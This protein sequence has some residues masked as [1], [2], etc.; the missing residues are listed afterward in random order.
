MQQLSPPDHCDFPVFIRYEVLSG[1]SQR[2]WDSNTVQSYKRDF[3]LTSV[4]QGQ[5]R[6]ERPW[7]LPFLS[8]S[9]LV[10]PNLSRIQGLPTSQEP[11]RHLLKQILIQNL[12]PRHCSRHEWRAAGQY[13][14]QG[15]RVYW[16]LESE[17]G[18]GQSFQE[19]SVFIRTRSSR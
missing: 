13:H 4:S 8:V 7:I 17:Q 10:S 15:T 12:R 2:S 5:D 1:N 6:S 18:E 14:P 16:N 11:D 9:L 3:C 19:C